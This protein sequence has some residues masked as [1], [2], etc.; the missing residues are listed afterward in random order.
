MAAL[1]V[2]PSARVGPGPVAIGIDVG[3]TKTKGALVSA[4]GAVA[5]RTERPTERDAGTK[6][7]IAVAEELVP[8]AAEAGV[9]VVGIGVGAAGFID[10]ATGSVTFS[11]NLVYD[12]PYIADAVRA[13][14]GIDVVVDNDANA[15]A[16]GERAFGV[17]RGSEHVSYL[18]IGTGIGS[19]F[20]VAGRL[21]RGQ[22]G[23]GA[24]M[25]HTV[26]DPRGPLCGCG[27]RG[28]LEQ[29][30]S[31]TAIARMAR[32]ALADDPD[33]AI[34]S[35]ASSL[36]AVTSLEVAQAAH[37]LDETACSV[38]RRAGRSLAL[39]LSNVVNIFD[40]EVIVLGGSAV[41]AGE[42]FLGP[43]RDELARLTQAQRRRPQRLVVTSLGGDAGI[44]GAAALAFHPEAG[45]AGR[46]DHD[47]D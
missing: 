28:C 9:E 25:G 1:N 15:A 16:W 27:L 2:A 42:P 40:P 43:C 46:G 14:T 44:V 29:F 6:G 17:A 32:A 23:A 31:G 3:G 22:T 30:A 26:I 47:G 4:A 39:G 33:S 45:P 12:D 5:L 7:I 41:R 18:T 24:E 13:R 11:P 21:V 10:A 8:R 37:L 20:I 36:E 38:L 35:F 19:G 34:L